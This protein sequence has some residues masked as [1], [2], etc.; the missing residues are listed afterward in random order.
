MS[1]P[2]NLSSPKILIENA[3]TAAPTVR[4]VF[5]IEREKGEKKEAT[6]ED[7]GDQVAEMETAGIQV[8]ADAD[9]EI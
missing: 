9:A 6:E 5:R 2:D 1:L 8:W 3:K 7:E 4:K